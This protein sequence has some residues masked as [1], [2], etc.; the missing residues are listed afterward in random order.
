VELAGVA[1]VSTQAA[2]GVARIAVR[3]VDLLALQRA[4]AEAGQHAARRIGQIE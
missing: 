2:S 4:R 3:T 1:F